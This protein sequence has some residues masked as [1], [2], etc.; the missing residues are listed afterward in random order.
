MSKGASGGRR[1]GGLVC[2]A[3]FKSKVWKVLSKGNNA[4]AIPQHDSLQSADGEYEKV[5]FHHKRSKADSPKR[6]V[7]VSAG[8]REVADVELTAGQ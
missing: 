2:V 7:G 5:D 3:L 1:G 8:R 4:L 6:R